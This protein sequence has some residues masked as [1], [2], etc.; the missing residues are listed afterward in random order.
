MLRHAGTAVHLADYTPTP[1][2]VDTV[3]LDFRLGADTTQVTTTLALTPRPGTAAGT[4]LVLDGDELTLV[5]LA[6][7][8]VPL[9]AAAYEAGPDSLILKVPPARPFRLTIGT[10]I[11]PAANAALSGLYQSRGTWCTQCEAEGFRRITY[12]P[13]RP[14]VLAVY[15]TRIE[16]PLAAAPVLLANGNRIA[17]GVSADG[18]THFAV[19]HDPWPKPSYLFAMVAGD[20]GVVEDSFVTRS[21]REVALRIYVEHGNEPRTAFAMDSLKRAMRWDEDVFGREYD[22]DIFMIV[23]VSDF[24]M[25]AMENK[26]LN[27][28]NDKYVLADPDSATDQDYAGIERVIAH[29]YFHNWTGNR[30][31]CRDWFQLCLKEGL[32]VFRDQE[33]S[34]DARSRAVKRIG[35]VRVLRATQFAEDAGPLA[36][37]VRPEIYHEINN[38]YTPTI[39]EKGAELIRALKSLLGGAAFAAG[40]E[41]YFTRHDGDAA[42]IEDFI[43]CFAESSGRDLAPFLVWYRQ[44]GTPRLTVTHSHD[45]AGGRLVLDIAQATPPTPGQPEKLPVP[46]PLRFGL[47]GG[48]GRDVTP[49]AIG[50]AEVTGDVLHITAAHHRVVLEGIH[51]PVVPS[52]LRGFSAPVILESDLAADDRLFLLARDSDPFSRWEAAQSLA[53]ASLV[54]LTKAA[55]EGRTATADTAL[56]GALGAVAG[57]AALDPAFRALVLQLPSEGDIAREIGRDVDPA[58]IAAARA[59]L[60]QQI[61]GLLAPSFAAIAAGL[62]SNAPYRP[63]AEGSGRRALANTLNDYLALLPGGPEKVMLAYRTADNMTDRI[64][65][66]STLVAAGAPEAGDALA[67]FFDR[68][69][70]DP[71]AIDKWFVVQATAPGEATLETVERLTRHP[72]FAFSNPNRVRSLV[73]AFS[74]S[75]P[76]AFGRPDGAGYR[77]LADVVLD[78]DGRNPQL[79]ARLLGAFR[80]WRTLESGRSA[81]AQA[82]LQRI[83]AAGPLSADVGDIVSRCLA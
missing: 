17:S 54:E 70:A 18:A 39:Y 59:A 35:D 33:F 64:A 56:I 57:N 49:T 72:A 34:A 73:G 58:A 41:L 20:L 12:F 78:L 31:T 61:A 83:A 80:T 40:L 69:R 38:F 4:P 65:A 11:N 45:R 6:L 43:A 19:W 77:F 16:A 5:S 63:D 79:A 60:K 30:I 28:F 74:M 52:L 62:A 47:V 53:T 48:D 66:L 68:H 71:L 67:D 9:D 22:L 27:I 25:G 42:T 51:E 2:A 44:A 26:G 36:H 21:G 75:N 10:R 8:G 50:G 1:Y 46:I 29:E 55:R 82:Q 13:D 37:P 3:E 24:N 15:T 7:D 14:D 81:L 76:A 32:T 23:A